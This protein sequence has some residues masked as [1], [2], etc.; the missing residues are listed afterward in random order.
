MLA[1]HISLAI[2]R[3]ATALHISKKKT[4]KE[5]KVPRKERKKVADRSRAKINASASNFEEKDFS[6]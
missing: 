4:K 6:G 3:R 1:K 5:R 2:N